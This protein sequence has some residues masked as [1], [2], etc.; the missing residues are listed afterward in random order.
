[1][2]IGVLLTLGPVLAHLGLSTLTPLSHSEGQFLIVVAFMLSKNSLSPGYFSRHPVLSPTG[3]LQHYVLAVHL[4]LTVALVT[5]P[6]LVLN[7][8]VVSPSPSPSY[9]SAC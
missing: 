7:D 5:N 4:L 8:A 9:M 3:D 1:M 6:F 2:D